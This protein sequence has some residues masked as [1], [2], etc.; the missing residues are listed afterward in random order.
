MLR[1]RPTPGI[2]DYDDDYI[3]INLET[4]EMTFKPPK[5]RGLDAGQCDKYKFDTILG[6]EVQ[7]KEVFNSTAEELVQAAFEG[8]NACLFTY[9]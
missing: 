1:I 2:D 8:K 5:E 7:Q 9:G 4:N 6:P 3:D